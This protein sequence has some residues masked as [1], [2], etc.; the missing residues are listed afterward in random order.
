LDG[1]RLIS[2]GGWPIDRIGNTVFVE[3]AATTGWMLERLS[4]SPLGAAVA[5]HD[6]AADPIK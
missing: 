6:E 2:A 5:S 4:A 1:V 3:E